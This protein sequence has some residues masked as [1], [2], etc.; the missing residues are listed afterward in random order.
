MITVIP[1]PYHYTAT[2]AVTDMINGTVQGYFLEQESRIEM[3]K[4]GAGKDIVVMELENQPEL[5]FFNDI[6]DDPGDWINLGVARYY[7]LNSV[8]MEKRKEQ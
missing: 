2:S 3:Y 1:E 7:N 5:L 8:S 4:N 6:S